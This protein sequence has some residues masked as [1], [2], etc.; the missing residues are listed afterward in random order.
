MDT[1]DTTTTLHLCGV[2]IQTLCTIS[3]NIKQKGDI[4]DNTTT[5]HLCGVNIET[6]C[7]ISDN[8]KREREYK[9]YYNYPAF[10]WC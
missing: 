6:Q 1:K 2:N 9:G 4:E 3:Y 5:L 8:K 10:M 7:A